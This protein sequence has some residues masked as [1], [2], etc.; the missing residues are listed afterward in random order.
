MISLELAGLEIDIILVPSAK[1]IH[2]IYPLPQPKFNIFSKD[3]TFRLLGNPQMFDLND[4]KVAV[5]NTDI[6]KDMCPNMLVKGE[7]PPTK[8]D[9]AL[10][11][12]LQ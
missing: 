3:P 8:I 7:N 4:L 6:V 5:I 11:S 10:K 12:L 9:T 2:H 1:D